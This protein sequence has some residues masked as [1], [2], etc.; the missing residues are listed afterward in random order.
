MS[1]R[2]LIFGPSWLG[3]AVMA[4]PTYR[5]LREAVEDGWISVLA[6]GPVADLYQMVPWIDEVVVYRRP[7]GFSRLTAYIGLLR[8][9]QQ[10]RADTA[11]ILPRSFGSAWTAL[12]SDVPR[13]IGYRASGRDFLLTDPVERKLELLRTHRVHYLQHLLTPLGIVPGPKAPELVVHEEARIGAEN[14]LEPLLRASPSRLV[15]LNPGANYGSAK[16]WPEEGFIELARRLLEE[17]GLSIVLV[18]GPGDH[19][20]CERIYHSVESPR[21]L[22]LSGRTSIPELAAVLERCSFAVSND[23]GAMHVAAAVNTPIIAIF[24][25]TDPVTTRPYGKN[26]TLLRD[27]VDCSPCLL[28]NC[29]IDHRCMTGVTVDAVA[30]ACE[31]LSGRSE[32][33]EILRQLS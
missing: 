6:R 27:P 28:R 9:L 30:R 16:Q 18:G 10:V 12:L 33:D 2:F 11:I 26:H 19:P 29:P 14:L 13:R 8:R 1:H 17:S 15:A 23:T 5:A 21:L 20:V 22:D 4:I 32:P 25:P 3:D 31:S 7:Q 24:G